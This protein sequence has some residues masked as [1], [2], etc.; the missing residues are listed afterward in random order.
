MATYTIGGFTRTSAPTSS[1]PE[2]LQDDAETKPSQVSK[3]YW[4][5]EKSNFPNTSPA[6][7]KWMLFYLNKDIDAAWIKAKTL[8]RK[9]ALTGIPAMKVSTARENSRASDSNSQV[10]IFYCGPPDDEA[11]VIRYGENLVAVMNY[12]SLNSNP[13]VF[14]K[15]DEQTMAGTR[16]TGQGKNHLYKIRVPLGGN[17]FIL[18]DVNKNQHVGIARKGKRRFDDDDEVEETR[19]R[20][21]RLSPTHSPRQQTEEPALPVNP[22]GSAQSS[23]TSSSSFSSSSSSIDVTTRI[24]FRLENTPMDASCSTIVASFHVRQRLTELVGFLTSQMPTALTSMGSW[25]L[26]KTFPTEE[27]TD[28]SLTIEDAG[29]RNAVVIAR[30]N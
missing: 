24:K 1:S 8:M 18:E 11:N 3:D 21:I 26:L 20:M 25:T 17:D 2:I 19:K 14:Y 6:N 23:S 13:Y 10:I 4:L 9:G 22:I 27:L 29:L 12:R 30:R 7:G 5:Y 16:A 15:S 28:L